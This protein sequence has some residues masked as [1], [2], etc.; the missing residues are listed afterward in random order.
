[1]DSVVGLTVWVKLKDQVIVYGVVESLT[2]GSHLTLAN[3]FFPAT[4]SR[5]ARWDIQVTAIVDLQVM[6]DGGPP[7]QAAAPPP[8]PPST[9]PSHQQHQQQHIFP[10]RQTSNAG[11]P[12]SQVHQQS[13]FAHQAPPPA[14]HHHPAV[15][16][17]AFR[18]VSAVEI[19][20]AAPTPPPRKP[21]AFIDPA[22][23][24]FANASPTP[25]KSSTQPG[26]LD[27]PVKS[28]LARAA[29]NLPSSPG[30]PFIGDMT[31]G[32]ANVQKPTATAKQLSAMPPVS[33]PKPPAPTVVEAP[34]SSIQDAAQPDGSAKKKVRRGQKSK[35]QAPTAIDTADPP[36]VMNAEVSRNGN[37]MNG[38]VKRGK[39]WRSTPLLQPSPQTSSPLDQSNTKKS[40]RREKEE[41]DFAQGDTTDIQDMG[42]FDFET[43]LKKFDKKTVFDEIRQGDTTADEDRLVSHNRARPGTYGGKNLHPTENVLSPKLEAKYNSH[44]HLNSSTSDADTELNLNTAN[45]RSSSKHSVSRTVFP[46]TKPARQSSGQHVGLGVESR[47]HGLAASISTDRA[48]TRSTASLVSRAKKSTSVA[49]SSPRPDRPNSP[50]SAVSAARKSEYTLPEPYFG[51]RPHLAACPTLLPRALATLEAATIATFGL[52]VD[53]ITESAARGIA[54]AALQLSEESGVRRPSRTNTLR[55]SMSMT[56]SAVLE[57]NSSPPLGEQPTIVVLAGNHAIGARALAAAR[58]LLGRNIKIIVAESLFESTETQDAH[59]KTQGTILRRMARGGASL[60]RGLWKKASAYIKA[61]PSPP[62]III[63]ALL[64]GATYE[65]LLTPDSGYSTKV[66]AETRDMIDW[67]NRSRAS[68]LSIGCPSGVSGIDG[69]ATTVEGE[70]LAVRPAKVLALGAP[71][72]GLLKATEAGE[73]WEVGVIDI[74]IN[75]ALKSEEAVAFG[76]QGWHVDLEYVGGEA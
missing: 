60:K 73:K 13:H 49:A 69:L 11:V 53:A 71:F 27:T 14:H 66:Q 70:P 75:I 47:Q 46:R 76:R 62:T 15:E 64:A 1:M 9:H 23:V 25:K 61:L 38:G 50:H 2:P 8:P 45:G 56:S 17:P 6:P 5:V 3:V 52:T 48:R 40:R 21:A 7:P 35:K 4:N 63:D 39:G 42:D 37:D 36:A 43:E 44:D 32:K 10:Q 68:V 54:E 20:P 22:I 18:H 55:G 30:S 19:P 74:G 16:L 24:S 57:S 12:Q 29:Q 51:I 34:E 59:I 33:Q 58:H 26:P 67:A 41:L 65:S 31:G 72:T 28:M